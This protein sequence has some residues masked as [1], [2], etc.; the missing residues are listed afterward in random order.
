MSERL[1][2]ENFSPVGHGLDNIYQIG[3]N[4]EHPSGVGQEMAAAFNYDLTPRPDVDNLGGLISEVGRNKELQKNIA[5]AQSVLGPEAV[6]TARDW[7]E[8]SGLL[9]PVERI[10]TT[11]E[12]ADG[13]IDLAII[14]GG[15][16]NWMAR[17]ANRLAELIP[18]RRVGGVLLAAGNRI[19]SPVEGPD[20]E[21]GMTEA[22]YMS[23][24]IA[25]KLGELGIRAEL[26]RVETG[27]GD[28]VMSRV[29]IKSYDLVNSS[30][31]IAVVSNAGNWVQNAGQYLRAV[32]KAHPEF[33]T[34][35]DQL[36]AVS[37]SF[38]LGTGVEPA[39]SHQNPLSAIGQIARNL[40]EFARHAS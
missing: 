23:T 34:Q 37:D 14:T 29:A 32:K 12:Q 24:V 38:P 9:L 11:A 19:M 35:N 27:V 36:E 25:P 22:D 17:R 20:V 1:T 13:D 6:T 30:A 15:V 8:R 2:F 10:F 4:D 5:V 26:L 33:D 40:Q 21:E 7:A 16:R 3:V 28:E 18:L 31:H 39:A